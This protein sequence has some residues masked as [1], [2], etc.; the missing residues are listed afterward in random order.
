MA[1]LRRKR[2]GRFGVQEPTFIEVPECECLT[3]WRPSEP[4]LVIEA[5]QVT[6][7]RGLDTRSASPPCA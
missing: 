1:L 4:K 2:L 5:T 3:Q 6:R 7:G